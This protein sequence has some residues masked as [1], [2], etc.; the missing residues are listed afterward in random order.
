MLS[1][2]EFLLEMIDQIKKQKLQEYSRSYFFV[3]KNIEN[4]FQNQI[5]ERN[6]I[7]NQDLL[8]KIDQYEKKVYQM[9]K[10]L[11]DI[12]EDYIQKEK[13]KIDNMLEEELKKFIPRGTQE[14]EKNIKDAIDTVLYEA[15]SEAHVQFEINS[16]L[17]KIQLESLLKDIL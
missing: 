10:N 12:I 15:S 1:K 7:D 6:L 5:Q 3:S 11:L 4:T 16:M 2:K 14:F 17:E 13:N 8:K 9:H